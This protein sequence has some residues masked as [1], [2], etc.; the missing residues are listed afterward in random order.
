ME[1]ISLERT[2]I[3][4]GIRIHGSDLQDLR[5]TRTNDGTTTL[6]REEKEFA[7]GM[8]KSQISI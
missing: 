5:K 4:C 6:G 2:K 3:I 1:I 8:R 7:N